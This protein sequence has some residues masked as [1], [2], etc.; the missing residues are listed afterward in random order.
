MKKLAAILLFAVAMCGASSVRAQF[1][2]Y[3]SPQT[4]QQNLAT[5]LPCT[6]LAQNFPVSNL[7]QTQ[8]FAT[9]ATVS[10]TSIQAVIQGIDNQGNVFTISDVASVGGNVTASGYF[11]IVRVQVTCFPATTGTFTLSYS[12]ASSTPNVTAGTYLQSQV[13]K[14]LFSRV[15]AN[16]DQSISFQTPFGSSSGTL[17]FQYVTSAIAGSNLAIFCKGN[18]VVGSFKEFSYPLAND[19]NIQLFNV[20]AS[21]CPQLQ[22]NYSHGGAATALNLEYIFDPPG[23]AQGTNQLNPCIN[24]PTG[25]GGTAAITVG[26]NTTVQIVPPGADQRVGVCTLILSVGVAGTV[27]LTAGTGGTCGTGSSNLSGAITLAVGTPF[28]VSGSPMAFPTNKA[29]DGVCVTTA[30]GATAAGLVAFTYFP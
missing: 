17:V 18:A 23:L 8:H 28:A 5:N 12:G 29:G 4:V 6:G 15:A 30:G 10:V 21:T 19:T 20:P 25:T 11:P 1:L 14:F 26:A 9:L 7:G 27:Q 24:G 16:A 13:D 2:G 3:T 22:V